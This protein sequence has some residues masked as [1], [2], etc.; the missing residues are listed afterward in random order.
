MNTIVTRLALSLA[1]LVA[2]FALA[3]E[4]HALVQPGY[5]GSRIALP[6]PVDGACDTV[7][8]GRQCYVVPPLTALLELEFVNVVR[9][10]LGDLAGSLGGHLMDSPVADLA[11]GAAL[12]IFP[13]DEGTLT[14]R[15]GMRHHPILRRA[16]MHAG[17]DF[18]A[19][20]GTPVLA[21]APGV[22]TKA[23]RMGAYGNIVIID[24]GNGLTTR[25]AHL[26]RFKVRRG[27]VVKAGDLIGQVGA[28]GRVTGAHLHFEARQNERPVNPLTLMTDR[29]LLATR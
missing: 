8:P 17:I 12:R 7:E 9:S 16:K 27:A 11:S 25:Y 10:F 1:A 4:A 26:R 14:S 28:T 6:S 3:G 21:A 22:V 20:S 2:C 13:V 5:I 23:G 15:F 19:R 18:G 24:H 29:A